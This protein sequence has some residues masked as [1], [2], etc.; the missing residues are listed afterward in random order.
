[1][2]KKINTKR[3]GES[4]FLLEGKSGG[5]K[6]VVLEKGGVETLKS[7]CLRT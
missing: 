2:I 7:I 4:S 6:R 1:M 3:R 5:K